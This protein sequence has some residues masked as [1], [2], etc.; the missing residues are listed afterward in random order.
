[1]NK[2]MKELENKILSKIQKEIAIYRFEFGCEPSIIVVSPAL[3]NFMKE[4]IK[5]CF[6]SLDPEYEVNLGN[7]EKIETLYSLKIIKSNRLKNEEFEVR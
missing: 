5:C 2:E 6:R 3:Y 4:Y 1:M 7:I